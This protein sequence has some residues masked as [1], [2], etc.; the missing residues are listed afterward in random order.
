[1]INIAI[2][3]NDYASVGRI[4]QLLKQY[5]DESGEV[6]ILSHFRSPDDILQRY[7]AD[8][9]IILTETDLP[10]MEGISVAEQIRQLDSVVPIIFITARGEYAVRGY[11]VNATA[12]LTKPV[13]YHTL[14]RAV[15]KARRQTLYNGREVLIS[16]KGGVV[17]IDAR[18]I[19]YVES[20]GHSMIYHTAK[21]EIE[22]ATTMR[23]LEER[24][25]PLGFFRSGKWY[26]INLL[27]TTAVVGGCATV[28]GVSLN[29]SRA[30]RKELISALESVTTLH[31]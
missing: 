28:G 20:K 21:G 22:S 8:F 26:L 15:D 4:K 23:E 25:A 11:D 12:F 6:I 16:V 10:F 14:A 24:L 5:E 30:R 7:R 2:I 3:D 19:Y 1:M 17:R 31:C 13:S 27:H 18:D 9:D 29:V